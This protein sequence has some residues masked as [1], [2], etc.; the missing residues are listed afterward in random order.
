MAGCSVFAYFKKGLLSSDICNY[1]P[2]SLTCIA[3]KVIESIIRDQLNSY[4]LNNQL[5]TKQQRGKSERL[6]SKCD[7][8]CELL[9]YSTAA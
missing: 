9:C 5:I 7:F 6:L 8:T 4:L 1:R 3:C 2:I